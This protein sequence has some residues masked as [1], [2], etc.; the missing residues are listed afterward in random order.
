[1]SN[2]VIA[3]DLIEADCAGLAIVTVS[4]THTIS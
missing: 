2:D 4:L 3:L 1:M